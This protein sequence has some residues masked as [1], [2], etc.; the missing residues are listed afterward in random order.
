MNAAPHCIGVV[1]KHQ[2]MNHNPSSPRV[3]GY[4][5]GCL[6]VSWHLVFYEVY[7]KIE[8]NALLWEIWVDFP[9]LIHIFCIG[10]ITSLISSEKMPKGK[11]W[12]THFLLV[13]LSRGVVGVPVRLLRESRR[14][15][16]MLVAD[17]W[18]RPPLLARVASVAGG[19]WLFMIL[20][21][22]RMI[23]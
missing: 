18:P 9:Y 2:S 21:L 19:S 23:S 11:L 14:V 4:G 17:R 1:T 13:P 3:L 10:K 7:T 12:A 6:A 5:Q 20:G 15:R 22:P 8:R 16:L